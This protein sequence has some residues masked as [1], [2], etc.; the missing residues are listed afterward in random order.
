[1]ILRQFAPML[2]LEGVDMKGRLVR[3]REYGHSHTRGQPTS[4]ARAERRCVGG[5]RGGGKQALGA[6]MLW[7]SN[8]GWDLAD[9][10]R[11]SEC[12]STQGIAFTP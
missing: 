8:Q 3:A 5:F 6:W 4:C 11:S 12:S 10:S 7:S 1:M 9:S 2:L